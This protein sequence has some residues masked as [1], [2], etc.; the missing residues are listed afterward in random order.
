M[1]R[2]LIADEE[3]WFLEAITD[4]L[5]AEFGANRYDFVRNGYDALQLLEQNQ[6]SMIILDMMMPL[7]GNLQLPK[8]DPPMMFGVYILQLIRK[9]NKTIPIICYTILD[10]NLI[11]KQIKQSNA[12]HICKLDDDAYAELFDYIN[13]YLS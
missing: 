13:K 7:G 12:I 10:D 8:H 11:K 1:K 5:D 2:I 3:K 9:Q 4:R 6:Y